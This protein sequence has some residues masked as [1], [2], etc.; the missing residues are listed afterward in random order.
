MIERRHDGQP[1]SIAQ[2]VRARRNDV[3]A[4]WEQA[5]RALPIARSLDT[6]RL[7]DHLPRLLDAIA[8]SIER[9]SDFEGAAP[10][11]DETPDVHALQRLD[12]GYDLDAVVT[13]Y[14]ILRRCLLDLWEE[15]CQGVARPGDLRLL[16]DAL[17][18]AIVA[19][20]ARY[21]KARQRA[22]AALERVSAI[23]LEARDLDAFLRRLL[24]VVRETTEAV[25][26]VAIL[27]AEQDTLKMRAAVG[28]ET[29]VSAGFTQKFGEGLAGTVASRRQPL[30]VHE[31]SK[32]PLVVSPYL[33]DRGLKV[34]Y[35]V[36]LLY[37]DRVIGVTYMGS[38]T[39]AEFAEEDRLILRTMAGRATT[40]IVQHQLLGTLEAN[41]SRH[42][43]A[44]D[45]AR[46]G[47]F[48]W[49]FQR[50]TTGW[51]P[52]MKAIFGFQPDTEVSV[53]AFLSRV[54]PD[55][56]ERTRRRLDM[57][58][59]PKGT[60]EYE[61]EY[62]IVRPDGTVR[63]ISAHGAA[64]FEPTPAG[65]RVVRFLGAAAD[66]TE[67]KQAELDSQ[68]RLRH[69][70][71]EPFHLLVQSVKDYAIYMLDPAGRIM[72]WNEG[73]ER[74]KGY[75]SDEVIGRHFSIFFTPE[76]LAAGKPDE[77][78]RA[79]EREGHS[80][81]EEWRVRK[82]GTRFMASVVITA[83]RGEDGALRGFAKVTR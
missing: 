54:H 35:A 77:T 44:V 4:S 59:D 74:L 81:V 1:P 72:T 28:V 39:A 27:L 13:E 3:L 11:H 48:D 45:A 9:S 68:A 63:W 31:G 73:A 66:N 42:R 29:A 33:R 5:V 56:R 60:G 24:A 38:Q 71:E 17:D 18:Q 80:S 34:I 79:A 47:T 20:V 76:D 16:D 30:L 57:A 61:N 51:S 25:D 82:D 36:P 49:D 10:L 50:G 41:E 37:D 70:S 67:R 32:S 55:D 23:A 58:L 8:E 52:R 53:D 62:R 40:L 83:L 69:R 19:S 14:T 6:E 22:F 15:E 75:A 12:Q 2:F 43:L 21:S 46:L 78:L 65:A 26:T 64:S 7:I